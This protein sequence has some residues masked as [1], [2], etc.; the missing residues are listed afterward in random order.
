MRPSANHWVFALALALAACSSAPP[1]KP[2]AQ[3]PAAKTAKAAKAAKP[4]PA[5]RVEGTLDHR[6]VFL[7]ADQQAGGRSLATCVSRVATGAGASAGP[8][9]S[10]TIP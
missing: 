9:V 3:Q 2:Q 4:V 7:S 5:L 6:D 8:V 1:S 10:L